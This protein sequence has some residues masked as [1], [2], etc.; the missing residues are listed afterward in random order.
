MRYRVEL[1]SGEIKDFAPDDP[2]LRVWLEKLVDVQ[3]PGWRARLQNV[4]IR[5]HL[6]VEHADGTTS[7]D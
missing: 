7:D 1:P 3:R 6:T 2:E 5:G 4:E